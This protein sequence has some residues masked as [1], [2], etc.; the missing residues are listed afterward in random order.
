MAAIAETAVRREGGDVG[1]GV[2]ERLAGVPQLQLAQ[3]GSVDDESARL[4]DDELAMHA[5]VT[6]ARIP[7]ADLTSRQQLALHEG[8]HDR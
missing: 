1:K 6:A 5:R 8:V 7:V 2:V 4:P 3:A